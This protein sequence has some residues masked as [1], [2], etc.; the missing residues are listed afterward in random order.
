M[1]TSQVGGSLGEVL[2]V[3]MDR[4]PA[5]VQKSVSRYS[6]PLMLFDIFIF[7]LI[8]LLLLI[9]GPTSILWVLLERNG[10]LQQC[11][12]QLEQPAVTLFSPFPPY[13]FLPPLQICTMLPQGRGSTSQVPLTVSTV[14]KL[15][16]C[17][18]NR[19]LASLIVKAG[20]S[21][22]FSHPRVSA[23]I[24]AFLVFLSCDQGGFG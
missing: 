24:S 21:Q 19:A 12:T 9:G 1:S 14:S 4:L 8:Y 18:P 23:Q 5:G 16:L 2:P 7:F 6:I 20:I 10:L 11:S 22:R 13:K 3:A 15:L 17:F